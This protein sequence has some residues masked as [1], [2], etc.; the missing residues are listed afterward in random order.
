MN[1]AAL[2]TFSSP[3]GARFAITQP[4]AA[5]NERNDTLCSV[6]PDTE[7]ASSWLVRW[8]DATELEI[9][10]L[11]PTA[12]EMPREEQPTQSRE[13][14]KLTHGHT[15]AQQR[16]DGFAYQH[17]RSG[18]ETLFGAGCA[19]TSVSLS[20]S[21]RTLKR[22]TISSLARSDTTQESYVG[23]SALLREQCTYRREF[24]RQ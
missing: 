6:V 9:R 17:I 22:D 16:E 5:G 3:W 14:K 12:K 18:A 23:S 8:S 10:F 2:G 4:P 1:E 20:L 15:K 11:D 13:T 7:A 19:H 21:Q 24:N